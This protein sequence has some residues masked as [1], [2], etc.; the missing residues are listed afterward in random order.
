MWKHRRKPI[1]GEVV[2][3]LE[4]GVNDSIIAS[5]IGVHPKRV[6]EVKAVSVNVPGVGNRKVNRGNSEL[7]TQ[8]DYLI[9]AHDGLYVCIEEAFPEAYE[10]EPEPEIEVPEPPKP[11]KK[12]KRW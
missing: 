2:Q 12:G 4:D 9:R 6:N 3:F 11:V 8:G 7:K 10:K 5:W 1:R